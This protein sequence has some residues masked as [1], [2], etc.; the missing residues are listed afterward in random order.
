MRRGDVYWYRCRFPDKKRPVVVLTRSDLLGHLGTAT[1]AAVT[2]TIRR[3]ASEVV[4]GP[5]E[6]L[7]RPCAI[8]LHNVFTVPKTEIGPY[9]AGL[10]PAVMA[11][12]DRALVFALGAGEGRNPRS[13]V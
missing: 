5:A 13:A 10:S 12:L 11:E 6:G 7:P 2:S 1:V 4:V 3:T 9:L 8:N